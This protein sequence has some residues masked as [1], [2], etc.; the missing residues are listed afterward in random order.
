MSDEKDTSKETKKEIDKELSDL[1]DSK[2]TIFW[3]YFS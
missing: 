2:S 1:L 3:A